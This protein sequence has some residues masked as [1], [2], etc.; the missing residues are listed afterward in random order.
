M[1]LSVKNFKWDDVMHSILAT[2]FGIGE[3]KFG[4]IIY[5]HV[6]YNIYMLYNNIIV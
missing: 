5:T 6:T 2:L 1:G 4:E 3:A